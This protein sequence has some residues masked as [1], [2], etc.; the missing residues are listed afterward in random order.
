[1][2]CHFHLL[3]FWRTDIGK[4][5]KKMLVIHQHICSH[6]KRRGEVV[7]VRLAVPP[8]NP[9]QGL[10]SLEG[11]S[12]SYQCTSVACGKLPGIS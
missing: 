12:D 11:T 4:F 5:V 7:W 2:A 8:H 9:E 1:M 3:H 6:R 10:T